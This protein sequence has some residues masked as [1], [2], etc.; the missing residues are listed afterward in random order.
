M[1]FLPSTRRNNKAE[2]AIRMSKRYYLDKLDLAPRH[3]VSDLA[4]HVY[5]SRPKKIV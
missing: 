4:K 1:Y 3:K 5:I 2:G